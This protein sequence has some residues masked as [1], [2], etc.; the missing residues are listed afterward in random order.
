MRLQIGDV[1]MMV[2]SSEKAGCGGVFRIDLR[3]VNVLGELPR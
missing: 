1:F 3:V 2:G